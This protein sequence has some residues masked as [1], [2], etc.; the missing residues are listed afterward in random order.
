MRRTLPTARSR[1]AT[2]CGRRV[3]RGCQRQ[4]HALSRASPPASLDWG[5]Y[6]GATYEPG[7]LVEVMTPAG[8]ELR[9]SRG[10]QSLVAVRARK[11]SLTPRWILQT[12]EYP[13]P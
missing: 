12:P 7:R 3:P 6:V 13:P 4:H 2:A 11:C 5:S 1:L 9:R 8:F 10:S